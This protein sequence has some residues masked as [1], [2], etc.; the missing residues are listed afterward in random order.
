MENSNPVLDFVGP[1]GITRHWT[2]LG[3]GLPNRKQEEW[4]YVPVEALMEHLYPKPE[5]PL[6]LNQRPCPD[7]LPTEIR[8]LTVSQ[9]LSQA[10]PGIEQAL[11]AIQAANLDGMAHRFKQAIGSQAMV[12]WVPKAFS[13]NAPISLAPANQ[14]NGQTTDALLILLQ[15]GAEIDLILPEEATSSRFSFTYV[16]L[17]ASA[18]LNLHRDLSGSDSVFAMSHIEA[19]LAE[20]AQFNLVQW[21]QGAAAQRHS[22]QVNLAGAKSLARISSLQFAQA[23]NQVHSYVNM[24]HQSPEAESH[25]NIR[26]LALNSGVS[27]FTGKIHVALDAQKTQAYQHSAAMVLEEGGRTYHRPVLE[28]Y[29]DDVKCSHG[30]TTGSLDEQ[31]LFYLQARGISKPAARR[32]LIEA[33]IEECLHEFH[34]SLQQKVRTD[35]IQSLP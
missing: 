5:Q 32:L 19:Q 18:K 1:A 31:A 22:I 2:G 10:I 16:G 9:A 29:A 24:V 28:I 15:A 25:Q 13:A 30:A 3:A 20:S 34:D 6:S 8:Y 26:Q 4:K 11:N 35:L 27:S 14:T 23:N 12:L 7:G 21:L 33:F 17:E